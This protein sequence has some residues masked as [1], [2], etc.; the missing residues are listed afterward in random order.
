MV[1]ELGLEMAVYRK[2]FPA[3]TDADY[4]INEAEL[5]REVSKYG[6]A[7]KVISTDNKTYIDMEDLESMNV[8]DTYGEDIE[9]IPPKI[10]S[11]MWS[12]LWYMYTVLGIDYVDVWPR[13]FVEVNGR[14]WIIDFGDAHWHDED[15]EPNWYLEEIMNAGHII[16]WNCDFK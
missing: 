3:G 14:V 9:C 6:L 15:E 11:Q 7:P 1:N 16:D 8:G 12:I 13:N 5:Q 10:L 2:T 4:I